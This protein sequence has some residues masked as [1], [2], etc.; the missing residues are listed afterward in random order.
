MCPRVSVMFSVVELTNIINCGLSTIASSGSKFDYAL[1]PI[2]NIKI[3]CTV[4]GNPSIYFP[5]ESLNEEE[6]DGEIKMMPLIENRLCKNKITGKTEG[7]A[8]EFN[9]HCL[10]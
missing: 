3:Q 7:L 4:P 8:Y 1:L 10:M 9:T 2:E 6:V 5:I